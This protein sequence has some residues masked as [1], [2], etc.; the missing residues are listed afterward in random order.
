[1]NMCL[2]CFVNENYV[3][4]DFDYLLGLIGIVAKMSF[5]Y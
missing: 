2:G 4:M 5:R 1:M 3:I